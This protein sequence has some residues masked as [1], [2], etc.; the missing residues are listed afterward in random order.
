MKQVFN[1]ELRKMIIDN[2]LRMKDVAKAAGLNP[3]YLSQMFAHELRDYEK[4][5]IEEAITKLKGIDKNQERMAEICDY[6][7]RFP[8]D[9]GLSQERL[10]DICKNCPLSEVMKCKD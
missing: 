3:T 2:G 9:K 1:R 10:T 6:Y 5:R 8:R 4:K 7:C